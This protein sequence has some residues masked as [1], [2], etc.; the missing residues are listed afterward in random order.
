MTRNAGFVDVYVEGIF[1][2]EEGVE[3]AAG[4]VRF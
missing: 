2:I 1:G 4:N 3:M